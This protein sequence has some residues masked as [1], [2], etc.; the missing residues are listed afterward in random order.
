MLQDDVSA[1][2]WV[3]VSGRL[4]G[5]D[6]SGGD[7][8]G[9]PVKVLAVSLPFIAV[10]SPAGPHS[11]DLR[12]WVVSKVTRQYVRAMLEDRQQPR[13]CRRGE[14]DNGGDGGWPRCVV[15]GERMQERLAEPGRWRYH[16]GN[17]GADGETVEA[18][19]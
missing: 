4:D 16:C 1:G 18:N 15:C 19:R 5:V 10:Q 9:V 7:Y 14:E 11:V 8:S 12:K 13:R 2:M 17:C 3:V 6:E